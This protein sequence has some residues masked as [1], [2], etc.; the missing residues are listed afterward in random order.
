MKT[1]QFNLEDFNPDGMNESE[2]HEW[3]AFI[4]S[5]LRPR[6]AK[7]WFPDMKD[8]FRHTRNVRNY[9]WNK[10]TAMAC[11]KDGRIN[12]AM[13]YEFICDRIYLELPAVAQW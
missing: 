5:G 7:Q 12:D 4:G 1:L 6:V 13:K 10:L 2:L 11:R 3:V 9:C 8:Q